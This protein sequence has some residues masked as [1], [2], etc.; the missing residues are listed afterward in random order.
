[1]AEDPR[2]AEVLG[3]ATGFQE[4]DLKSAIRK[5]R[6]LYNRGQEYEQGFEMSE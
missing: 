2:F 4:D 5:S 6:V 3:C 1:M